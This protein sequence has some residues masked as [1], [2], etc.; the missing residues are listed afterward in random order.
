VVPALLGAF[1]VVEDDGVGGAP[2]TIGE[3]IVELVDEVTA[4]RAAAAAVVVA[5]VAVLAAAAAADEV[6]GRVWLPVG[7][8]SIAAGK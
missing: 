4:A 8:G 3:V 5:V 7:D 6:D 1:V 2:A